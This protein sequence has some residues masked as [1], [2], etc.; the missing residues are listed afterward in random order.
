MPVMGGSEASQLIR[1]ISPDVPIILMSGFK[2]DSARE[3]LD[4]S[5]GASFIQKPYSVASLVA[6]VRASLEK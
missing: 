4:M 6:T 1:E 2:E 5:V 3:D